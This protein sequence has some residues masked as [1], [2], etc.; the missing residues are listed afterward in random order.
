MTFKDVTN[1]EL[2]ELYKKQANRMSYWNAAEGQS[3]YAEATARQEY[4]S[5]L[6]SIKDEFTARSL[7]LPK[8]DWLL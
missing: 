4:Q 1:E 3:Y 6:K 7:D 5:V 2:I 8:G